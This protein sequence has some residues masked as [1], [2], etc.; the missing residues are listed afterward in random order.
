MASKTFFAMYSVDCES[1]AMPD[2]GKRP[3]L[4]VHARPGFAFT[5]Q[6]CPGTE[7]P[8]SADSSPLA[9]AESVHRKQWKKPPAWKS[10]T[11]AVL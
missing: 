10:V 7:K 1:C 9:M 6:S 5:A 8:S 3:H 2:K 11:L 4:A